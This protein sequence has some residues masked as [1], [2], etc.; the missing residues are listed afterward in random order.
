M[1]SVDHQQGETDMAKLFTPSNTDL[2][3]MIRRAMA[4]CDASHEFQQDQARRKVQQEADV[5]R[6]NRENQ[7]E[8]ACAANRRRARDD[9]DAY[10]NQMPR[11]RGYR[12]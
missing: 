3:D 2:Q 1:L 12:T 11:A 6:A 9:H 10:C 5:A 7:F 4:A 8:A